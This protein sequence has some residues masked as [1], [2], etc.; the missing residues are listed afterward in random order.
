MVL[1]D[2]HRLLRILTVVAAVGI[3]AVVVYLATHNPESAP[4]LRCPF[5]AL[6]G[7]DCPGCGTQRAVHA[8][9]H[10]DFAAAWRYNAALMPALVL[11]LA[12]IVV[13]QR[14][15]SL[16]YRPGFIAGVAIA[17]VAWWILRNLLSI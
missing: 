5:K 7:Y 17:I 8:L 4:A 6:T 15:A 11:A 1:A 10:A 12:Y 16:L 14:H 3:I 9:F 2:A 13:P